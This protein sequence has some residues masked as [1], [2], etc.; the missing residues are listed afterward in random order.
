[1]TFQLQSFIE[2]QV[3][4]IKLYFQDDKFFPVLKI[5]QFSDFYSEQFFGKFDDEVK[6]KVEIYQVNSKNEFLAFKF[7]EISDQMLLTKIENVQNNYFVFKVV[8]VG[9]FEFGKYI[10]TGSTKVEVLDQIIIKDL[11]KPEVS[12]KKDEFE[13]KKD[14]IELQQ[15][16]AD[17]KSSSLPPF[18]YKNI[19]I[20][21]LFITSIIS[22][23]FAYSIVSTQNDLLINYLE[24]TKQINEMNQTILKLQ[25]ENENLK[26]AI[27][28]TN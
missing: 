13:N 15:E 9:D 14:I 19:I 25:N 11:I 23:F 6:R 16:I 26:R 24:S 27:L 22:S 17:L 3:S 8:N 20:A 4:N 10:F 18:N 28:K 1:M 21:G 12:V 5:S 7:G 2:N